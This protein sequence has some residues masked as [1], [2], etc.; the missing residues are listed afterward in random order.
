MHASR[1]AEDLASKKPRVLVITSFPSDLVLSLGGTILHRKTTVEFHHVA[2]FSNQAYESHDR[3][4]DDY[5]LNA[6]RRDEALLFSQRLEVQSQFLDFPDFSK[7]QS[8]SNPAVQ[9]SNLQNAVKVALYDQIHRLEP[10][11]VYAPAGIGQQVDRHL[12]TDAIV[13]FFRDDYFP[14]TTFHLYENF[15]ECASYL[16]VDS[17]LSRFMSGDIKLL[18]WF[19]NTSLVKTQK[20]RLFEMFRSRSKPWPAEVLRSIAARNAR[21]C[22]NYRDSPEA[23]TDAER[24]WTLTYR[25]SSPFLSTS[26][27]R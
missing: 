16:N 26:N 10:E 14:R 25:K 11:V 27:Q 4:Y 22:Q 1:P 21:L 17:F 2:V 8:S 20:Q 18:P 3:F 5:E 12:V 6:V 13:E 23:V 24:F 7:R 19:E 9:E 15:I